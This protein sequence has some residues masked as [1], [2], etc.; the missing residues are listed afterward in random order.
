MSADISVNAEG[1]ATFNKPI[2]WYYTPTTDP[3]EAS[4]AAKLIRPMAVSAFLQPTKHGGYGWAGYGEGEKGVPVTYIGCK[5]DRAL[6]LAM[7]EDFV[8][9]LRNEGV[10]VSVTWLQYDH[11]PYLTYAEEVA[12]IVGVAVEKSE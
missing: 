7:Q 2:E 11:S 12:Q 1:V 8:A 5:L 10:S 4:A 9:R 3:V 6:P